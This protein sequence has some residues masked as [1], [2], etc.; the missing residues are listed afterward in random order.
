[1]SS[2]LGGVSAAPSVDLGDAIAESTVDGWDIVLAL[3]VVL[4]GWIASRYA[5]R[6]TRSL[7]SRVEGIT[8][9]VATLATRVVRTFVLIL[10]FGVALTILGAQIQPVI[11]AVILVAVVSALALRGIAENW[12]AGIVLQ[13]RRP[14]VVGD[15]VEIGGY[16]GTVLEVN[17]H[18]V[19]IETFDGAVVHLP[20]SE[21][22][23]NPIVNRSTR[24][25]RRSITEVRISRQAIPPPDL[26]ELIERTVSA[27]DGVL[28]DPAVLTSLTA[29]DETRSTLMVLY[30]HAPSDAMSVTSAVIL[31]IGEAVADID[32]ATTIISPPP[33]LAPATP[34][35]TR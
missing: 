7:T 30:W 31:A 32:P 1:M 11:A 12:A 2:I 22:L 29:L 8:P 6:A 23:D 24:S 17:G 14:I 33:L 18:A 9:D 19:V 16:A 3:L 15:T 21:T 28:D 25:A 20:N 27:V 4:I 34:P 26:L 13:T 10:G 35:P 5:A